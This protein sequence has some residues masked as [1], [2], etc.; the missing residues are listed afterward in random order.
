MTT[1]SNEFELAALCAAWPPASADVGELRRRAAI[2]DWDVF[3]K[4]VRRHRVASVVDAGLR[5]AGLGVPAPVR[6]AA[7]SSAFVALRH[8]AETYRLQAAAKAAKMEVVF[9]KGP[10]LAQEA[11]GD[12]GMRHSKDIDLLVAPADRERIWALMATEGYNRRNPGPGATPEQLALFVKRC[13]DSTF[14]H[15]V[16]AVEVEVHWRM[17]S[18]LIEEA[19]SPSRTVSLKGLGE[20]SVLE[21]D[22][23]F[24]YLCRHGSRHAWMRLKWLS[25]IGA[26]L[27][28]S[29]DAPKRFW[30][31]AERARAT[32]PV[33]TAMRL[34]ARLF[35]TRLPDALA[36][37][38]GLRV[39]A[40]MAVSFK[41]MAA[42]GGWAE[43]HETLFG[44]AAEHL[45]VLILAPDWRARMSCVWR[46]AAPMEDV[47]LV[48][49]PRPLHVLYPLIRGPLWVWKNLMGGR[50]RHR[51]IGADRA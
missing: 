17:S 12:C 36:R 46:I 16:R 9:L 39:Q 47:L 21:E 20:V 23:E 2:V 14:H 18:S 29:P 13:K 31:A 34:S 3:S 30:R 44:K 5:N 35:H 28:A 33:E 11:F 43:P 15:P 48:S 27:N 19:Q 32:L 45:A 26:L 8:T 37:Q 1:C 49:L 10:A 38:P 25:D 4:I 42:S 6:D 50:T 41:A 24:I 51:A 40:L 22:D 7:R